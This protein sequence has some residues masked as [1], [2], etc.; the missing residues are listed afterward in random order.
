MPAQL[1]ALIRQHWHIEN[2][3]T[4]FRDMM[5]TFA[6]VAG[7]ESPPTDGISFVPTMVGEGGQDEHEWLYWELVTNGNRLHSQAARRGR[8]KFVRDRPMAPWKSMTLLHSVP[9][10]S[11]ISRTGSETTAPI[12]RISQ[13]GRRPVSGIMSSCRLFLHRRL[14]AGTD[15]GSEIAG[16]ASPGRPAV[17]AILP[18]SASPAAGAVSPPPPLA[19]AVRQDDTV[20]AGTGSERQGGPIP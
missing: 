16:T 13:P 7:V 9:I 17:A 12:L 18:P 14:V 15:P 11:A 4:Y 10:L 3:A 20:C 19:A 2:W 8:W 6:E 5:A 1:A